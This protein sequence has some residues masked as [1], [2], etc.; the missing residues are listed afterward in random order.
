VFK[1]LKVSPYRVGERSLTSMSQGTSECV[2]LQLAAYLNQ[3]VLEHGEAAVDSDVRTLS[4]NV[5]FPA[6]GASS[7]A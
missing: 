1:V 4:L 3:R 5:D 2:V 6:F 7:S